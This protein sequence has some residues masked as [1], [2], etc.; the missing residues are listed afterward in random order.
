MIL[1]KKKIQIHE[2]ILSHEYNNRVLLILFVIDFMLSSVQVERDN[3]LRGSKP[4]WTLLNSEAHLGV[5]RRWLKGK[6]LPAFLELNSL[7]KQEIPVSRPCK[8]NTHKWKIHKMATEVNRRDSMLK[9]NGLTNEA[10]AP[11][12]CHRLSSDDRL[13]CWIAF[14]SLMQPR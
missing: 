4:P 7:K 6:G 13:Y 5:W 14:F 10:A 12:T 8:V 11:V 9:W 3:V 1:T 2:M